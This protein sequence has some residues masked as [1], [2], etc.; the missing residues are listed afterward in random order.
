MTTKS[1]FV[2]LASLGRNTL[3]IGKIGNKSIVRVSSPKLFKW[4][5]VLPAVGDADCRCLLVRKQE[6]RWTD[7]PRIDAIVLQS[8]TERLEAREAAQ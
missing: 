5:L 1:P 2:T 7:L 6:K 4:F 8:E 3:V